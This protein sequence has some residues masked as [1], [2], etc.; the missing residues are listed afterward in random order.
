MK[1]IRIAIYTLTILISSVTLS[2]AQVVSQTLPP[3]EF[4]DQLEKKHGILIDVIPK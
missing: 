1:I 3:K 2:E 4:K